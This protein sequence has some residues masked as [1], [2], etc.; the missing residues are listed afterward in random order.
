M[1]LHVQYQDLNYDYV[2]PH[3]PD[4]LITDKNLQRFYRPSFIQLSWLNIK[5]L[6]AF[7]KLIAF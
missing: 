4:S 5:A 3:V 7:F 1:V 2:G 6:M